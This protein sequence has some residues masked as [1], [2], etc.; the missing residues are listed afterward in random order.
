[1][2]SPKGSILKTYQILSITGC[3]ICD[4]P[5]RNSILNVIRLNTIVRVHQNKKK[6]NNLLIG[7][8][9]IYKTMINCDD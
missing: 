7:L 1:M 8:N 9:Q 5:R 3:I 2:D 6:P 4:S